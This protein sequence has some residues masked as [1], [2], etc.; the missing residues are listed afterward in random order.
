M[1]K[2]LTVGTIFVSGIAVAT[3]L[4]VVF[5]SLFRPVS[6]AQTSPD[7]KDD[8]KMLVIL[9]NFK[10]TTVLSPNPEQVL[11]TMDLVNQFGI[12]R[13][14]GCI[15]KICQNNKHFLVIFHIRRGLG[16]THWPEKTEENYS[17][18]GCHCDATYKNSPYCEDLSH[19]YL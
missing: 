12:W 11:K 1:R 7:V 17:E 8:Q 18:E 6:Y 2:I 13:E 15:L 9:A 14:Y 3:L 19:L 10:D 16:I 4:A 5:F